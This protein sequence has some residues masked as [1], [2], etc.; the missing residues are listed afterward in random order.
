MV[1][2]EAVLK[3]GGSLGRGEGLSSL[4]QE[5]TSLGKRIGLLVVPGGGEF[6]DQVRSYYRRY[7]LSETA[8]HRMALLAMDQY[9]CLLADLIPQSVLVEDLLSAKTIVENGQVPILLPAALII[10]ADPLPHSWQV[11]SD[12]IAA[13]VAGLARCPRLVLLKDI[14]GIYAEGSEQ[15]SLADLIANLSIERLADHRG[16]VDEYLCSILA[17]LELE[18]WVINGLHPERLA[19]LLDSGRTLGTRISR[20]TD[21]S[22]TLRFLSEP[23]K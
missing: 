22:S 23:E 15:G 4:C 1:N 16:G 12:S 21:L 10:Q 3:V 13:W 20:S 7:Q 11:T 6:A 14:D 2:L 17:T 9:A 19:E 5:I 18:T 8:A